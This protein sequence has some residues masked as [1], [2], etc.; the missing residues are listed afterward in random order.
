ML[1]ASRAQRVLIVDNGAIAVDHNGRR[2]VNSHT[3]QFGCDTR[4]DGYEPVFIAPSAAYDKNAQLYNFCLQ[5]H[6]LKSRLLACHRRP[7]ALFS[8]RKLLHEILRSGFIYIFFPGTLGKFAALLCSLLGRPYGL[9]VRGSQF[10]ETGWDRRILRKAAFALTVSP[11][12][13]RQIEPYC[14]TVR[15]IR[16]MVTIACEDAF[17]RRP[18]VAP[19][20][21]WELL[22]VG[23]LEV[24]KGAR[25]L[26]QA[27]EGLRLR[28]LPFR[29]RLVGGGPLF[30]DFS[31]RLKDKPLGANVQIVGLVSSKADLMRFYRDAHIF[32]FPSYH[33]G[34]PRVLYEAMIN[35]LPIITTMVGG[36]SGRMFDGVNCIGI[37]A[38]SADSIV[39]AVERL[40]NN[41]HLLATIGKAGRETAL[42]VL[43]NSEPHWQ[44]FTKHLKNHV[45]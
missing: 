1:P 11:A 18:L 27:A 6:A 29:L 15:V 45:V 8:A 4:N 26:I 40:T 30:D 38:K 21:I 12:L 32:I 19:P 24:D 9:Y 7:R 43:K 5:D 37:S 13:Q 23:R 33:E 16:P 42:D 25:E 39:L 34:F 31:A 14:R 28:G 10:R 41:L 2:Y 44:L 17:D 22:F 35:S 20:P 36:I 3:G